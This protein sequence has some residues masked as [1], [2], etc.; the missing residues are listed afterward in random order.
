[1]REL[2][3]AEL[4]GKKDGKGGNR[5]CFGDG[6]R[7]GIAVQMKERGCQGLSAVVSA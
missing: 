6:R 5:R 1:V 7:R 2:M 3:S 4:V